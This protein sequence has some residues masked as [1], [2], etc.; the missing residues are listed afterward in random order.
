MAGFTLAGCNSNRNSDGM[1]D[2][3]DTMDMS[4]GMETD[5]MGMDTTFDDGTMNQSDSLNNTNNNTDS[6]MRQRP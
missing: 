6:V 4:T 1:Q 2:T 5:T 3:T